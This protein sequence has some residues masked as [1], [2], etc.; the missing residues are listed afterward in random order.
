[1][2]W[3]TDDRCEDLCMVKSKEL[4]YEELD[5]R[6]DEEEMEKPTRGYYRGGQPTSLESCI[7]LFSQPENLSEG[8]SWRCPR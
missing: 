3:K 8:D 6:Q 7:D 5:S 2:D 4:E 1:M